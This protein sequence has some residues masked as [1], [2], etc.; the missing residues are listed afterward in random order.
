MTSVERTATGVII[1]KP[2]T[3]IKKAVLKYFSL[4][5][6]TREYFIYSGNDPNGKALFG[7]EKDVIYIT[8]GF[9]EIKDPVIQSLPRGVVKQP[10]MPAKIE[11]NV[12]RTPR[13]QLQRDCIEKLT[14]SPSA[15]ITVELKPGTGKLEPYSRKIPTP[16]KQ[17]WT[18]MGQLKV[19]DFVFDR[20][21]IVI[22][23]RCLIVHTI[24]NRRVC[25]VRSN[26]AR[27]S[28]Q[29]RNVIEMLIPICRYFKL[30]EVLRIHVSSIVCH[31]K[32]VF[33]RVGT[34]GTNAVEG[35]THNL[36]L[37]C[38]IFQFIRNIVKEITSELRN[39]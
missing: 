18:Y 24:L 5:K 9:L 22:H 36:N 33:D 16:T 13:S 20:L 11:L 17:G 27:K 14:K 10:P 28:V 4:L 21:F 15:K 19:G 29:I 6:P 31:T 37:L 26:N 8:S 30:I 32:Q 23:S 35:G 2:T 25:K 1:R 12:E 39:G 38:T 34:N 3:D 7:D